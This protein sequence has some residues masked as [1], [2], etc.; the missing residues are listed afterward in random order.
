MPFIYSNTDG[1]GEEMTKDDLTTQIN[2]SLQQFTTSNDYTTGSLRV[3]LNGL[4]MRSGVDYEELT[5]STF[6]LL[7]LTPAAGQ[8]LIVEYVAS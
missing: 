6:R 2:G 1:G 7:I 8:E 3:Y 4:Y 5:T